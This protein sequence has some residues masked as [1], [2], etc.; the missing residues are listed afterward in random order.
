MVFSAALL[1]VI[2]SL[3]VI[4]IISGQSKLK[5]LVANIA[6]QC[7]KPIEAFNSK[8][9]NIHCDLGMLKYIMILILVVVIILA[10]DKFKKSRIFR[11]QFFSNIVQIKLFIEDAQ[12]Y[13]PIDLSKVAGNVHMFKLT[14]AL[15]LGNINLRKTWIWDELEV[16][17]SDIHVPLNGKEMNLPISVVIPLV[18]KFRV[19]W[20]MKK[21]PLHLHIMLKQRESW[22]NL[23]NSHQN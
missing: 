1:T 23:E 21:D 22:Y 11:G 13:V 3:V 20:L 10:F 12:S 4:Y 8:Y 17:W 7:I 6:L 18:N 5:M 16:D 2:V 14:G 9:Q 19:R 15:L